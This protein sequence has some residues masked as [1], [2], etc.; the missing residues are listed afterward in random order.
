MSEDVF[1]PGPEKELISIDFPLG[2]EDRL[3]GDEG[4]HKELSFLNRSFYGRF[5]N[6]PY[7]F[8]GYLRRI[9]LAFSEQPS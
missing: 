9:D 1:Q 2:V 8:W 4:F 5:V 3:A 6:R 7:E